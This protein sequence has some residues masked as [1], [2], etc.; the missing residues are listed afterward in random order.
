MSHLPRSRNTRSTLR[1]VAALTVLFLGA[2]ACASRSDSDGGGDAGSDSGPIKVGALQ[3][4]TG[5][6]ATYGLPERHAFEIAIA[7]VNAAGGVNGRQVE[8]VFYDPAGDTAQAVSQTRRLVEQDKVDVVVGGGTSS[9]IALA[10][11][12][13][14]QSAGIFFMSTE[15]A[16]G[17][18][19]P[20]AEASTTFAT[21]LSTDIVVQSMFDYLKRKNVTK[22]G[23]LADTT[24]YGQAGL[25]SAEAAAKTSGLELVGGEYDPTATDL[26]PNINKLTAGGVQAWVNWTSGT[27]GVL[28]MR[29]AATLNLVSRGPVMASFTYSNP[30]L[31]T[32]AGAAAKGVTVAGVK[33]TVLEGLPQDDPQRPLLQ[34]LQDAQKAQFNEN[35][36]IYAS[37]SYDA[38][39]ITLQAIG[40]AGSTKGAD[41]AKAMEGLTVQGTQGE[42]KYSAED[43]RG[44]G[45]SIPLIM[46]W[47]GTRFVIQTSA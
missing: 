15:A 23:F 8:M 40:A 28:F 46:Q 30:A 43:H 3:S 20:A 37:Q 24:A 39:K 19:S 26:T 32:Q 42:Y 35:V 10:M 17:I 45:P 18:V 2:T 44:L 13:I 33:A 7:E 16:N 41:V 9:G 38:M 22:V 5:D 29:N 34:K 14:L 31:M 4:V 27:S 36:T 6:L 12:P 1:R 47:D 11:K 21:T 25:T